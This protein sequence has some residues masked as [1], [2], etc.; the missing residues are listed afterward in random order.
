MK[1]RGKFF[2]LSILTPFTIRA[3]VVPRVVLFEPKPQPIEAIRVTVES[4]SVTTRRVPTTSYLSSEAAANRAFLKTISIHT[5]Q[6]I[7]LL[8]TTVDVEERTHSMICV[9]H[10]I[11]LI[12]SVRK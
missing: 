7:C 12:M 4:D 10:L 11:F 8:C 9:V 5:I 3:S 2:T 1:Y 6:S